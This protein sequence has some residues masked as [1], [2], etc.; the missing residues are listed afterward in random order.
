MKVRFQVC[1]LT[2]VEFL[3][4]LLHAADLLAQRLVVQCQLFMRQLRLGLEVVGDA[5]RD[6]EILLELLPFL[7]LHPAVHHFVVELLS[8][9]AEQLF[10][11]AQVALGLLQER[12]QLRFVFR[13][14]FALHLERGNS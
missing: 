13:Q 3:D 4:L 8:L 10:D 2:F 5:H 7:V 11:V 12:L 1:L 6:Q 9:F 14:A